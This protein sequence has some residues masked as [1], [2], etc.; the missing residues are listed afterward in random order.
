MTA[1]PTDDHASAE[2][3]IRELTKDLSEAR[4]QQFATAE[5]LRVFSSSPTDPQRVFTEIATSAARLCDAFDSVIRRVDGDLLHHV[6]HHGPIPSGGTLP[7]TRGLPAARAVLDRRTIHIADLQAET[8]EFPEG[9]DRARRVGFRTL[10]SVPLIRAGEA[11]GVIA[12]RRS[13]VRP[14]TERQIELINTFADQAVIAIEN[15]RL[16]EAEQASKREVQ[17]SLEYQTAISNVLNVISRS[18]DRL[19][20][21]FENIAA[22]ALQLVSAQY[23]GIVAYDG[24]LQHLVAL[25]NSN[26]EGAEA[27]RRNFPRR[28]DDRFSTSRAILSRSTVQIPDVLDDPT[29][30]LKGVQEVIGFRSVMAVPMLRDS[31]PIGAIAVGRAQPGHFPDKHVELLRTFADQAVIAIENTRLFTE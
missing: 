7:L 18:P 21:V 26:P 22:S 2:R 14:F 17:E 16:F 9:S 12:I 31:E 11:I 19:Q 8:D 30:E 25:D 29:Y 28:L 23:V 4:E 27:I 10:L 3:R 13:E 5:I 15:T 24:E 20:P 6:A 1:S